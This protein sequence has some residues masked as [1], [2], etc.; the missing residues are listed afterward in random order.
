MPTEDIKEVRQFPSSRKPSW[1]K[2][3]GIVL[4]TMSVMLFLLIFHPLIS[5]EIRYYFSSKILEENVYSEKEISLMSDFK[6]NDSLIPANE[7]FGIVIPKIFANSKIV[8]DV[9]PFDSNEYQKQL[10][11]G[12]AH[13]RGS[14]YPDQE[15]NVF[16]FSHSGA[17][18]YEANRYNA[19][20]YLLNEMELGD[21]VY[22][23]YKKEKMRYA[24][25]DKKLVS[26]EAVEYISG[27]S[28][29]KTL[30]LMTCW[31]PGTSWKRLVVVAEKTAD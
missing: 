24:V 12:I 13:A 18:F 30:T 5:S 23:F 20:F 3:A 6:K 11:R 4:I 29:K 9:D 10:A 1:L 14:S 2:V 17:N 26:D 7:D 22:V 31:P 21:V 19:D 27:V 8:A 28:D 15:G 25:T 16:L